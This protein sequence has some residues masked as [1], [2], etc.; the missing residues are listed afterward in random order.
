ME[1]D[2]RGSHDL[3]EHGELDEVLDRVG[4]EAEVMAQ[5][6]RTVGVQGYELQ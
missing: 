3:L 4:C 2:H 6:R 5:N 1:T